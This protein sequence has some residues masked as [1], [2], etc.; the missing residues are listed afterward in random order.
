[1]TGRKKDNKDS[2]GGQVESIDTHLSSKSSRN[3][4]QIILT[5]CKLTIYPKCVGIC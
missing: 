4:A 2:E 1:M 5:L 3:L